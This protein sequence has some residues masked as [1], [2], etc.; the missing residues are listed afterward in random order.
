MNNH[1]TVHLK[2]LGMAVLWGASWIWGK[3][4]AENLP[5]VSASAIRFL[6]AGTAL[7][8]GLAASGR[9]HQ[10]TSLS[11]KQWLGLA[12][13]AFFGV[14]A[15]AVCF[16]TGLKYMPAGE[17]A[18]IVALNPVLVL[19]LSRLIFKEQITPRIALG[20]A[21]AF[22][23]SLICITRG[24]PLMLFQ[25]TLGLGQMLIL[26]CVVCWACYTII[27]RFMLAGI[28]ALT[29]TLATVW[30]GG[31]LLSVTALAVEKQS[32]YL[33]AD[34]SATVWLSLLAL[35]LGATALAYVWFFE[36]VKVLGSATAGSYVTMVPVFGVAASPVFLGERLHLSLVLGG[37]LA[38]C[39]M[40]VMYLGKK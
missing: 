13:S 18:V 15:Y 38:V 30:I 34:A 22:L 16:L 7:A 4:V 29:A 28:N 11:A 19:L 17:A 21:A 20:M 36:G 31:L 25:Q 12:V 27:G 6:L 23:G 5:P 9:L 37:T 2:L 1:L 33:M 24:N 32:F 8:V 39:G 40:L 35:A 14:F 26:G 10:L 3:I